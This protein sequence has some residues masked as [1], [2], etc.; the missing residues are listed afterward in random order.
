MLAMFRFLK[1]NEYAALLAQATHLHYQPN[2]VLLEEGSDDKRLF[3]IQ[4]GTVRVQ[5]RSVEQGVELAHMQAGNVF[6]EMSFVDGERPSASVIACTHV[7][8]LA[9]SHKDV[10]AIMLKTPEF[11][12]RF[13]QS[14]A[15]ILAQRLSETSHHATTA[16]AWDQKMPVQQLAG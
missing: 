9:V 10:L 13:Y 7:E 1:E 6:G 2:E 8:A 16:P 4:S 14:L 11:Y 12:G 5:H 3:L 15:D